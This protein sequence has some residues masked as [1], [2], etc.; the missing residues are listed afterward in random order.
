MV[1]PFCS[2]CGA[3]ITEEWHRHGELRFRIVGPDTEIVSPGNT[4]G[5]PRP[6]ALIVWRKVKPQEV[7]A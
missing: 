3:P 2:T 7:A 1:K 5:R 6:E 4:R